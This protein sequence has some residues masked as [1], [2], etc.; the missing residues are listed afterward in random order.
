MGISPSVLYG[1]L[2]W[3]NCATHLLD[4]VEKIHIKAARFIEKIKKSVKDSD[5]LARAKW[6]PLDYYYKKHMICKTYKI[7]NDLS[8]P[9]LQKFITKSKNRKT[10]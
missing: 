2:I 6:K 3:G 5:V 10:S 1:I 8:S 4:D 7:Y 9:L